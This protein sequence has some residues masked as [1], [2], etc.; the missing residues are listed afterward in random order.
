MLVFLT[1]LHREH[2]ATSTVET[3][4]LCGL[5]RAGPLYISSKAPDLLFCERI[6][7]FV[8]PSFATVHSDVS[9]GRTL[10][11]VKNSTFT[12]AKHVW[13][14]MTTSLWPGGGLPR[15]E[16]RDCVDLLGLLMQQRRYRCHRQQG[17][18]LPTLL[19]Y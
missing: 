15:S 12:S 11:H 1:S 19:E 8:A 3:A 6:V 14:T 17:P 5:H 16:C 4:E 9:C 13:E 2:T 7:P 10:R 18:G